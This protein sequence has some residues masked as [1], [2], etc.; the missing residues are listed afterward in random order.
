MK[1]THEV[2]KKV[3]YITYEYEN[4]EEKEVHIHKMENNEYECLDRFEDNQ[5]ATFRKF[6][7]KDIHVDLE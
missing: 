6:L 1:K 7:S 2:V 5:K 3:H 4:I